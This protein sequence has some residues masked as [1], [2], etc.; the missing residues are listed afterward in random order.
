MQHNLPG[1]GYRSDDVI[2]TTPEVIAGHR[3]RIEALRTRVV[4]RR[5]TDQRFIR[6]IGRQ[7]IVEALWEL[8]KSKAFIATTFVLIVLC[9]VS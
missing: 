5:K 3:A 8:G 6:R 7:M 4:T 1:V 2:D 9:F